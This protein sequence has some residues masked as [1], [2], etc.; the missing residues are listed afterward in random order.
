MRESST[1]SRLAAGTDADF[2]SLSADAFAVIGFVAFAGVLLTSVGNHPFVRALFGL[3]LLFLV[4][5]YA[6]VSTLFPGQ[7]A[8]A[9]RIDGWVARAAD[10]EPPV[11]GREIDFRTRL[12][13]S[14]GTSVA[15]Q[16]LVALALSLAGISFTLD[17]IL[18]AF[19][20]FAVLL[21][22]IA[23]LRRSQ[24]PVRERFRLPYDGLAAVSQR[25]VSGQTVVDATLN[26]ALVLV[27]LVSVAGI[28][29]AVTTPNNAEQFTSATLL[30]EGE[31][32]ELVT[33]G[34]PDTLDPTGSEFVVRLE[35]HRGES[36]D[37]TVVGELQAVRPSDSGQRVQ[38][39][40]QVL[41]ESVTLDRG[42]AWT[43]HNTVEPD[44]TGEN[45]RLIYYVYRGEAPQNPSTAS[46]DRYVHVWLDAPA[47]ATG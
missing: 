6:V 14:F 31:D 13:L 40:Q 25:A 44:V 45:L 2:L 9:G 23:V 12:A 33:G 18:A 42:A 20:G 29:Y 22:A 34:Y 36:T 15:L 41:R 37:Y 4:P 8:R 24:L 47:E 1:E 16:P 7:T 5:G 26:V 43:R 38:Q 30:T 11:P 10:R 19:S 35:N 3:P 28:G 27:V 21:M 17:T 39:S 46:A 32:G